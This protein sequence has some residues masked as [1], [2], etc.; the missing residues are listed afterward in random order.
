MTDEP[1]T[2]RAFARLAETV[3]RPRVAREVLDGTIALAR[4]R[5]LFRGC[6]LGR[7]VRAFGPVRVVAHGRIALDD[8]AFFL[9][10]MIPSEIVCHEGAE[11]V[12]G[13]R[14][15]FNYGV[16]LEARARLTLGKRCLVAAMVRIGDTRGGKSAPIT[17]GDDVWIAHGAIVEPGVT[18]GD[19][20]V[21]AAG[22]VVV[23]DVP[24]DR[25]A[26]GNPARA[27]PLEA[28]KTTT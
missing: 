22:S 11:I 21:V 7:R 12:V 25:M 9:R 8:F 16:S 10:G 5:F 15:G 20:S 28:R 6:H 4:A 17:I 24:A 13:E 27:V 19:R 18:I 2:D 14:S 3:R 23:S 26:I 1:L